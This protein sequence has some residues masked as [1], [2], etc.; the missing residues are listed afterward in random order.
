M[1][2]VRHAMARTGS[3]HDHSHHGIVTSIKFRSCLAPRI[4]ALLKAKE[5]KRLSNR[6]LPTRVT[7]PS[8][9][10]LNVQDREITEA[11]P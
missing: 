9:C 1:V 7:T 6:L 4:H 5:T 10:E 11:S 3:R 2:M 8:C